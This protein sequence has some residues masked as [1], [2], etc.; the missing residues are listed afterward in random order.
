M[1]NGI[2]ISIGSDEKDFLRGVKNSADGL[3]DLGDALKDI[4]K[5]GDTAGKSLE[6]DFKAAQKA[7]K[8]FNDSVKDGEDALRKTASVSKI[9]TKDVADDFELSAGQQK[10]LRSKALG[11][12]KQE[13]KANAAETFSS[14]D[15]SAA[16][17]ADG[18]QGTL[19]GLVSSLG[20]V[21]L[22]IGA[23]G[24]LGI[25]L[26]NGA[27]QRGTEQTQAFKD[28][29]A[30]LTGQFLESGNR[31]Q[32]A[33]SDLTNDIK[34]MAKETDSTKVSL[35]DLRDVSK[36]LDVPFKKV[37]AAYELG[38]PALDK[39]IAKNE[40]LAKAEQTRTE[41][42]VQAG[43]N[44]YAGL[45]DGGLKYE[46][47]LADQLA[48]LKSQKK[49]I[50]QAQNAQLE[51]LASGADAFEVKVGLIN[52]VNS[53][54]DDA[55]GAIDDFVNKETGI[56]D[57]TGYIAAMQAREKALHDYQNT[58]ATSGL[59]PEAKKFLQSEGEE[60]AALQLQGYKNASPAQ[61]TELNRIWSEAGKNNSGAYASALTAGLPATIPGPKIVPTID[62]GAIT[63]FREL[64]VKPL[65]VP[66]YL[67]DPR[68]GKVIQ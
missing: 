17:F 57:V 58:L 26:L 43:S 50:D 23:A 10:K 65:K 63:T 31:G 29:V 56:F 64:A 13:A 66:F 18:I 59:T 54:Y 24:A 68:T 4:D 44:P 7:T 37:V 6:T 30:E 5:A 47:K 34:T 52:Q 16:S 2:N 22:A 21:G 19:G 62:F 36:T 25:G 35:K 67:Q 38:G 60:T 40:A 61:Q 28:R 33:F 27:I 53:A 48:I 51:Y 3:D 39:L 49:A 12:I 41:A 45:I 1:A 46:Q 20:P 14:F 32:R 11:E 55:A 9:A 15:G 8:N 42:A